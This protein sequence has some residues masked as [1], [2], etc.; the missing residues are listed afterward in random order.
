M[1]NTKFKNKQNKIQKQKKKKKE[2][3]CASKV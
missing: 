3:R 1:K 2:N